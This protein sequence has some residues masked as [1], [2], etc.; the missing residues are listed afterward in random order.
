M[1]VDIK[2]SNMADLSE[3][4][5]AAE[6]HPQHCNIFA[7]STS[8]GSIK[9][10]DMREAALCDHY[11]KSENKNFN[12]FFFIHSFLISFFFIFRIS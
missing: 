10:C 8:K 7:Y 6:F 3:V 12:C 5:S 4:I 2:P 1:I 11:S 9:L